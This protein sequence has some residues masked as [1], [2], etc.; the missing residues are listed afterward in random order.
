MDLYTPETSDSASL[1]KIRDEQY[2]DIS[3]WVEEYWRGV[4]KVEMV[5]NILTREE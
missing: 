4:R 3:G 1:K 2:L 5:K